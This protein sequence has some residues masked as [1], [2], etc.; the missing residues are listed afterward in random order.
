M[1]KD[2]GRLKGGTKKG[3]GKTYYQDY[4]QNK[5][6]LVG[7]EEHGYILTTAPHTSMSVGGMEISGTTMRKVL[8]SPTIKDEDRPKFFKK[9]IWIL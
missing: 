3:G 2:G 9:T 5:D 6:N 1:V 8:G 7:F 4:K